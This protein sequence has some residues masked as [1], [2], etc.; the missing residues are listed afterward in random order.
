[1]GTI[2][3]EHFDNIFYVNV[4]RIPF[5]VEKALPLLNNG[6]SMVPTPTQRALRIAAELYGILA[7]HLSPA[8]ASAP[9]ALEGRWL[10]VRGFF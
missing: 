5:K 1:L 7:F 3:A 9:P 10:R 8:P 4:R 6:G 2:T